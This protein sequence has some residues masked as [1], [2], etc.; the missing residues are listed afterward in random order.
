MILADKIVLQRKKNGWSQEELS[1]KLGVT[2]QSVSKWEGAQAIPDL[3]RLLQMSQIFGVSTDYL[4]K[5]E[6]EEDENTYEEVTDDTD[7]PLRRVSMEEANR[8]LEVKR[9]TAPRIALATFMC[10]LSPIS[11]FLLAAASETEKLKL[12]ENAACGIGMIVLLLFVAAAVA[13]FISCGMKTK[14]YEYLETELIETEYGVSSAVMER[15]KQYGERYT[16]YNIC[17]TTLCILGVLPLFIGMAITENEMILVCMLCLLLVV[18]GIGVMF[19]INACIIQASF[20]KLLQEEDYS[21]ERKRSSKWN[22]AVGTV[23]WLVV[24]AAF[25]GYS[26]ITND[27]G[28]SWIIWPV[29]GVLF[30][31]VLAIRNMMRD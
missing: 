9:R 14:E 28:R 1:E 15:K 25:L 2:R 7:M 16:R 22:L 31:A 4:L 23:Y 20:Q 24:T 19:F 30:P 26:F 21:V 3:Q 17:G 11:L 6:L 5:D 13:I 12:S 10:M 18:E 8:F 27:W 29:A